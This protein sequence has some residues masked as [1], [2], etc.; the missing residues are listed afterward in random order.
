MRSTASKELVMVCIGFAAGC[1]A[2]AVPRLR[3]TA[4]KSL[5]MVSFGF[6]AGCEAVAVPR[7][8]ESLFTSG[9][10]PQSGLWP[11]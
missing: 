11:N 7:L 4:S 1:E 9:L 3:S 10:C 6:A 8:Q 5:V 2:V